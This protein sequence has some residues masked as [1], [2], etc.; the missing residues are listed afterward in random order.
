M[1]QGTEL[2]VAVLIPDTSFRLK[3]WDIR[4]QW[5]LC[6]GRL[7][8]KHRQIMLDCTLG[9]TGKVKTT[10]AVLTNWSMRSTP[11]HVFCCTDDWV[12]FDLGER[13]HEYLDLCHVIKNREID[14]S[15]GKIHIFL[16]FRDKI[17]FRQKFNV[18]YGALPDILQDNYFHKLA[19]RL[20]I[21]WGGLKVNIHLTVASIIKHSSS[22][23]ESWCS[24]PFVGIWIWFQSCLVGNLL[25]VNVSAYYVVEV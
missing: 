14:R 24:F 8:S 12:C 4:C 10:D 19:C 18:D 22:L 5:L 20:L 16:L 6:I 1:M 13:S 25:S 21:A 2:V 7:V 3:C 15:K 17:I 23:I 9:K 11:E